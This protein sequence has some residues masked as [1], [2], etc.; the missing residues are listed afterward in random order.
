MIK[1]YKINSS[2]YFFDTNNLKLYKGKITTNSNENQTSV[3]LQKNEKILYKLVFNVANT[4]NL[5]CTYCYANCGNYGR[6]NTLMSEE[7]IDKIIKS[8]QKKYDFIKT[9][10]FFGGEPTINFPVIKKA[11]KRLK[12]LYPKTEDYR[13]V[14]NATLVTD[15]MI[16]FFIDNGFKVYVS[17]DG[18][19]EIN[20]ALR[21]SNFDQLMRVIDRLKNSRV[22]NKLELICTYTKLHEEKFGFEKIKDFF[23]GLG[24]K[25]SIS[26]VITDKKD[27]KIVKTKKDILSQE[28]QYIDNSIE[29]ILEGSSNVGISAYLRN[30]I[31]ALVYK[32]PTP[33]FCKE[34]EGDYSHV[35]DFNGDVYP[36][37]R[38][39]GAHKLG[40]AVVAALNQKSHEQCQKCFAKAYCRD[41]IADVVLKNT[42]PCYEARSCYKKKL[43]D[44]AMEKLLMVF[45]SD[46][47]KFNK[48]IDN[49]Y[50]N[51][52]F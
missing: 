37:I 31:D 11:T 21:G 45:D 14:T 52:L 27:L 49:F 36:C 30:I 4:C 34:L 38:L 26:D 44:Y 15:E 35:Y 3:V 1:K 48:L 33:V 19:K 17:I 12:E 20:D 6:E 24:V 22:G 46:I 25:Y 51:Y 18:P 28:K 13:I 41:C 29:R 32:V 9:I 23:E 40:D 7:T 5:H 50:T 47:E 39:I 2:T 42:K 8:L 43:Y 16:D 10:Y